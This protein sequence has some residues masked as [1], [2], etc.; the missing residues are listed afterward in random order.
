MIYEIVGMVGT[1]IVRCES[2]EIAVGGSAAYIQ[3][4][5]LYRDA[6]VLLLFESHVGL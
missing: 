3:D 5:V 1:G 6:V 4:C 2:R